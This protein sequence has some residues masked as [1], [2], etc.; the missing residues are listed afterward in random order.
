MPEWTAEVIWWVCGAGVVGL[1]VGLLLGRIRR[2]KISRS[3]YDDMQLRDRQTR[4]EISELRDKNARLSGEATLLRTQANA[5]SV[6]PMSSDA[7]TVGLARPETRVAASST[8]ETAPLASTTAPLASPTAANPAAPLASSDAANYELQGVNASLQDELAGARARY[9][10]LH[11][12]MQTAIADRD[13]AQTRATQLENE[14]VHALEELEA[15]KATINASQHSSTSLSGDLEASQLRVA[16]LELEFATA[17]ADLTAA[18]SEVSESQNRL[19]ATVSELDGAR[20]QLVA[21]EQ[22]N[23][24]SSND[25][26]MARAQLAEIEGKLAG[27]MQ[28]LRG[29]STSLESVQGDLNQTFPGAPHTDAELLPFDPEPETAQI[30]LRSSQAPAIDPDAE[31]RR[32][33]AETADPAKF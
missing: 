25:L 26:Y 33:I 19:A 23:S 24:A 28:G 12:S 30:D 11:Q 20:S 21:I 8:T 14:R 4:A 3:D 15:A 7:A 18:R 13:A 6:N 5:M 31:T 2:P 16:D 17:N 29:A 10:E 22:Q 1:L 27:V 32:V 9:A